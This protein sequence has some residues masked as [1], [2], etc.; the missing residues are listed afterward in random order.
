M[1]PTGN[2]HIDR[3]IGNPESSSAVR[4]GSTGGIDSHKDTIHVAVITEL[5]VAV[6]DRE[7]GTTGAGYRAAVA[8]LTDRGH[9]SGRSGSRPPAASAQGVGAGP[10]RGRGEGPCGGRPDPSLPGEASRAE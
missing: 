9:T 4:A 1:S 6:D 2:D 8:W 10:G 5:G 3:P 7:F